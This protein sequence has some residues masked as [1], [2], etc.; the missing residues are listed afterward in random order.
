MRVFLFIKKLPKFKLNKENKKTYGIIDIGSD[1]MSR[2]EYEVRVLEIDKDEIQSK[3]KELNAV[4]IEDVFQKRYVYDFK[5]VVPSKWIRL[6]T[7][8]TKTTLTIK[9]VESS[10]IDGTS[11]VEIEVSDFDTTNEIL[12]ELGYTPRGIQEN[13]RIKYDLNG[14]EIDIDTWPKIP[15]YLEIEGRSEE[16]VY[17]TLQL[18]G[19]PKERSTSLDVQSIYEEI[20]GIDLDKSPNLSFEENK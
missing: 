5:P 19:I 6:R 11:E 14:V 2:I 8:G 17:N 12:K 4:L 10:N 1:N 3:L 15:T 18:L 13:K 20:Y 16:E 9:N 7:N